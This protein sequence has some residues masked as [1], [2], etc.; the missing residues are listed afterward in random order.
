MTALLLYTLTGLCYGRNWS[1]TQRVSVIA[2][3]LAGLFWFPLM[4]WGWVCEEIGK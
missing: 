1:K 2:S 4:I 3:I